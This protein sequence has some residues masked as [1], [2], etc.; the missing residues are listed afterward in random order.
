MASYATSS[1]MI[2]VAA[3][4]PMQ[5]RP[6]DNDGD[7]FST[8]GSF[9]SIQKTKEVAHSAL[10]STATSYAGH[11]NPP[12]F[13]GGIEVIISKPK[14]ADGPDADVPDADGSDD[15]V[16]NEIGNEKA[17][18]LR[19]LKILRLDELQNKVIDALM[20]MGRQIEGEESK[21]VA[22][23]AYQ[24]A[25]EISAIGNCDVP[26]I[27][28]YLDNSNIDLR[29]AEIEFCRVMAEI[30]GLGYDELSAKAKLCESI[31]EREWALLNNAEIGKVLVT[32]FPFILQFLADKLQDSIEVVDSA[33]KADPYAMEF[34]S[35]R[36]QFES[37]RRYGTAIKF[38]PNL[39]HDL[40]AAKVAVK[41]SKEAY[42]YLSYKLKNDP[43]ILDLLPQ[44]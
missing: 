34:A 23:A 16:K 8:V 40:Q 44:N 35:K 30:L 11:I 18:S 43:A 22:G 20:A 28:A 12:V 41:Q 9:Q 17:A 3:A 21:G 4:D 6:T 10:T 7:S 15:E 32:G 31:S 5:A 14:A 33:S 1:P 13:C 36:I 19:T 37:L 27:D 25:N 39:Q 26:S 2:S 24:Y 38:M 29:Q 42:K